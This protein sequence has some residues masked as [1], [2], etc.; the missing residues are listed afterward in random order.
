[1][2]VQGTGEES[3]F[4]KDDLDRMLGL[5]EEG[6]LRLIEL[7]REALGAAGETIGVNKNAAN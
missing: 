6:I 7:Q 1:M 4:S 3:P 2:E 5:A